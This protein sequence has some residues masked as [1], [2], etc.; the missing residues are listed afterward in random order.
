MSAS[1]VK[2]A[3]RVIAFKITHTAGSGQNG[4]RSG[5]TL[6]EVMVAM[7]I[8]AIV[9]LAVY[10]LHSQTL[11]MNYSARFYITAPLLAQQKLSELELSDSDALIDAT[12]DFGED[13][14]G[15]GWEVSVGDF[16]SELLK[17][18]A[19]NLKRIDLKIT[20]NQDELAYTLRT[21]RYYR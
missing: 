6:L 14:A 10:R 15:Y 7:S 17:T 8:I 18:A 21:Y 11:M 13:H 4:L 19:E 12:G 5:F 2:H 20:L 1:G 16:E 9:L 3:F